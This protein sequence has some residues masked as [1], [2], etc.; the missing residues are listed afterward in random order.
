MSFRIIVMIL[1]FCLL[2]GCQGEPENPTER[3]ATPLESCLEGPAQEE[4]ERPAGMTGETSAIVPI[5]RE[6]TPV[7][8]LST[9]GRWPLAGAFSPSGNEAYV[10]HNGTYQL[11]VVDPITGAVRYTVPG[12]GG[13]RGILVDRDGKWLITADASKGRVSRLERTGKDGHWDVVLSRDLPGAPTSLAWC[14]KDQRVLAVSGLSSKVW[15]LDPDDLTVLSEYA[16]HGVY[17]YDLALDA[18]QDHV[19]FS[20]AGD[21]KVTKI[22]RATGEVVGHVS[23]G[24]NPMG[25]AADPARG[26][27][28]VTSSDSDSL[29]V[30]RMEP[31]ESLHVVDVSMVPG[32]P[33]GSPNEAILSP[34]S[35]RL[36]VSFADLNLVRIYELPGVKPLGAIPAAFYPTGLAASRDG[37][38]LMVIGSKGWGGAKSLQGWDGVVSFVPLEPDAATLAAW[39]GQAEDNVTR[40]TDFFADSTCTAP[41]PLP[42]DPEEKQVIEH[43]VV[44]VRENKTYDTVLGDLETGDGD[45]NLAIFGEEFTPNLHQ[46]AREFVNLDNYYA[47]SE[48]SYQGHSWTSQADCNDLFEKLY[49]ADFNQILL[50]GVDPSSVHAERSIFDHCWLNGVT[51]RNYG[52]FSSF[53]KEIFGEWEGFQNNKFPYYNLSIPDVWKAK[54]FVRELDLGIFPDFVYIAL[55]NDHTAGGKAGMPTPASMVAD[56]DEATGIVVDAISRSP[57]WDS[58]IIF[59]IED[60]PQGYG[61]DHV[62]S[63]RSVCVVASPWLRR[64]YVSSVH[65]SIPSM[66]HTIEMLLR[67]PPMNLNTAL[68]APM[69]DIFIPR[70]EEEVMD[71][72]PYE[73]IPRLLPVEFNAMDGPMAK[74]SAGINVMQVDGVKG[75][76]EIIWRIQRGDEEPPP[77]AKWRDE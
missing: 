72:M 11:S 25:M 33:G 8:V 75:L 43:A 9:V 60:D 38:T 30:L 29:S 70:G 63:H 39:T 41:L 52:E 76:G 35:A 65:Y 59:I 77:Y 51:F 62:H 53:T 20:H 21:D 58:S 14:S 45:P 56:N 55:P 50:N 57:Y 47:D 31:F 27:L 3:A 71:P 17:P 18:T 68:A 46:L 13:F 1:G 15:E 48:E 6:V 24:L 23:V 36:I 54:E 7:G 69:L 64:G 73:V 32:V 2:L 67:L 16:T 4:A 22:A 66:Y 34:D 12:I 44:I 26:L 5:G 37:E 42:L 19:F 40:A 28:Y 61:G 49:P 10:V 74:A